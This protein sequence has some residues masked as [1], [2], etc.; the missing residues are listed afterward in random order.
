M[1]C[2]ALVVALIYVIGRLQYII[3]CQ[4]LLLTMY[5]LP[6]IAFGICSK[7]AIKV[8]ASDTL[9]LALTKWEKGIENTYT[10]ASI[11][12]IVILSAH[13]TFSDVRT[14]CPDVFKMVRHIQNSIRHHAIVF[15]AYAWNDVLPFI[16][17]LIIGI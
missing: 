5:N 7:Q 3:G 6:S 12:I 8:N 10:A 2:I 14:K 11:I 4:F 1:A 13:I 15:L 9:I 17:R 16:K